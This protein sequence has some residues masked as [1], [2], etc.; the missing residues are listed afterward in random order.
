MRLPRG[1]LLVL[2][3]ALCYFLAFHRYGFFL[4][5]EGVLAYHAQRVRDGQLPYA[6]FQTAYTPA[7]FYLHGL[8]FERFGASL[9]VLR[10]AAAVACAATAALLFVAARAVMASPYALVPS[11]LYVLLED[12]ESRGLVVHAIAYPSRYVVALWTLGL[13][14]TLAHARRPR[15]LL[16]VA[17]GLVTA[18]I[19]AFT[20]TAGIYNAWAVGL[21]LILLAER[22]V[23]AAPRAPGGI[24]AAAVR[25]IPRLFLLAVLGAVVMLFGGY[26]HFAPAPFLA[27]GVPPAVAC[28]LLLRGPAGWRAAAPDVGAGERARAWTAAGADL[29]RFGAAALLPTALWIAYFGW[30]AGLET[31]VQRLVLD[32]PA[33]ARSYTI[34]LPRPGGLAIGAGLLA[35]VAA[36]ARALARRAVIPEP[37]AARAFALV[38]AAVA[39]AAGVRTAQLAAHAVRA[40]DWLVAVNAVGRSLDNLTFYAVPVVAYAFL[41]RLQTWRRTGGV[42][43]AALVC[44]V[45]GICQLL[46]AYPRL[47]VAHLYGG[48]VSLLIPATALLQRTVAFFHQAAPPRRA[49]WLPA[50]VAACVVAACAVKLAPRVAAQLDTREGLNVAARRVLAGPRAGLYAT[51]ADAG[52]FAALNRTLAFV[53]A[54]TPPGRPI[55]AY[56]A[57]AA[58]YFLGGRHNPTEMDY[59]HQGFGEGRDEVAV[60]TA[61]EAEQVPL[62]V[63]MADHTFDPEERGYFPILKDY[64]RRHFVQ[65]DFHPPFRVLQRVRP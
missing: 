48:F 10:A 13:C 59:F 24:V 51:G 31:L 15:P 1:T 36:G 39:V 42:P 4:Q 18:V 50:A 63:M 25:G 34:S 8:L 46:L 47:D 19:I 33:V 5:D 12:Q 52:W 44:W 28:I 32:G 26:G 41:P 45:H 58:V 11:V 23:P 3:A 35:L 43:D 17:L 64:L 53:D 20:Q 6:D 2:L 38:A 61:L 21:S 37:A 27:L 7:N 54:R 29:L 55:F 60:V 22:D 65:T 57:L 9:A 62:V 49:R 14:L 30:Q 40:D 16:P 56:P